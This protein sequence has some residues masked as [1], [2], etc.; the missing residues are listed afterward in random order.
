MNVEAR[1][2][3]RRS[4]AR[5]K[6]IYPAIY[7]RYD[8]KG[9]AWDEKPSRSTNL[10]IGGM[11]LETSFP[12]NPKE[13]LHIEVAIRNSL[14]NFTG[15]VIYVNHSREKGFELGVSIREIKN[16]DRIALDQLQFLV[17]GSTEIEDDKM[18]IQ[19]GH[20]ICPNCRRQI[21]SLARIKD[22]AN[23]CEEFFSL[24][25]CGQRFEIKVSSSGSASLSFPDKH[26]E[27]IC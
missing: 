23:Y 8:D 22:M 18:I 4:A 21:A 17:E 19:M 12:V 15:E 2:P 24:C 26:I 14:V 7:T 3:E 10:S 6:M 1:I 25:A 5:L 9:R 13:V 20:I 27:L 11:R 16:L